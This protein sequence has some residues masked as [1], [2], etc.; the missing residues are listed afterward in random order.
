MAPG[1]Y[2]EANPTHEGIPV[3]VVIDHQILVLSLLSQVLPS[4]FSGFDVISLSA[5]DDLEH[6]SE[7]DLR[8]IIL[9][10]PEGCDADPLMHCDD[11]AGAQEG[12]PVL[13]LCNKS[14]ERLATAALARGYRGLVTNSTPAGILL[15][16][17]QLVLAGGTYFPMTASANGSEAEGRDDPPL[18]ESSRTGMP[19]MAAAPVGLEATFGLTLRELE[20]LAQL[21]RGRPNKQI[22]RDLSISENTAKAHVRRILAKLRVKNRIEA[23]LMLQRCL[24]GTPPSLNAAHRRGP[25][26]PECAE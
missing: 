10:P 21:R 14:D 6:I 2:D 11:I 15:A 8:L 9:R 1:C 17:I 7:R 19:T 22:A 24:D 12:V 13:L 3:I 26:D 16:A 23:V 20:V 5:P 25:D 4:K 18:H